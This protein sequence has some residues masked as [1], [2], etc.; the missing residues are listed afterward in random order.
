MIVTRQPLKTPGVN[1][2]ESCKSAH[3]QAQHGITNSAEELQNVLDRQL[4]LRML[5]IKVARRVFASSPLHIA[6][7]FSRV[8][9]E[10]HCLP[11]C[12]RGGHANA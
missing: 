8:N 6:R 3:H 4:A 1:S 9:V 12:I 5:Q 2:H 11:L 10:R 7:V